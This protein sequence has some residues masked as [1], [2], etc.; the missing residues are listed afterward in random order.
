[1]RPELWLRPVTRGLGSTVNCWQCRLASTKRDEARAAFAAKVNSSLRGDEHGD[2]LTLDPESKR[3]QTAAGDLPISPLM[4][5]SWMEAKQ[6]FRTPKPSPAPTSKSKGR[7]R[8]KLQLNPFAHALATP[9]RSCGVSGQGMPRHFLQTVELV[10][11]PEDGKAWYVPADMDQRHEIEAAT[12]AADEDGGGFGLDQNENSASIAGEPE[13]SSETHPAE[14][15]PD[16]RPT[17]PSVT[18]YVACRQD[19]LH[20][21]GNTMGEPGVDGKRGKRSSLFGQYRKILGRHSGLA[22]A[23]LVGGAVWRG[24]MHLFVLDEMRRRIVS[25]L[26]D[27]AQLGEEQEQWRSRII[28]CSGWAE[29]NKDVSHRGCVLWYATGAEQG[30]APGPMATIDIEGAVYER[31]LP[32]HNLDRLLGEEHLKRLR[33]HPLFRDH[34]L[35]IVRKRKT[36]YVQ[37]NLWKLQGYMAAEVVEGAREAT[38]AP[39]EADNVGW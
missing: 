34:S 35:F 11:N 2:T 39:R 9:W 21:L 23:G 32:V 4:D 37:W 15:K 28:P 33:G 27:L 8:K 13:T 1:M 18:G 36:M 7:F 26:L 29:I 19:L 25:E 38:E 3:I 31:T 5:P 12:E 6:R 17:R 10:S 14:S 24:D 16:S 30:D 22:K 20:A